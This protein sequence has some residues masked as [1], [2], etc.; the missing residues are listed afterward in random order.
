MDLVEHEQTDTRQNG[1]AQLDVVHEIERTHAMDAHQ[2]VLVGT[3]ATIEAQRD[4]EEEDAKGLRGGRKTAIVIVGGTLLALAAAAAA[5]EEADTG[6]DEAY[7]DVLFEGVLLAHEGTHDH[8]GDGLAALGQ[9]LDGVDDV[10]QTADGEEGGAH[11]G[12]AQD[13]EARRGDGRGSFLPNVSATGGRD[14]VQAGG[15]EEEGQ[16][17]KLP[18]AAGGVLH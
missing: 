8:D 1:L 10:P 18:A 17:V 16:L 14:G 9:D 11:R 7:V 4:E 2:L 13:G 12:E 3:G 15:N 5:H 6:H